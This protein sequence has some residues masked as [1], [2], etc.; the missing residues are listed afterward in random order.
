MYSQNELNAIVKKLQQDGW[1]FV[2]D[3]AFPVTDPRRMGWWINDEHETKCRR[4]GD[5]KP[6][7]YATEIVF[8]AYTNYSLRDLNVKPAWLTPEMEATIAK[9]KAI[10]EKQARQAKR[11]AKR[12]AATA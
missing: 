7:Y 9:N 2:E 6:F 1:Y 8:T 4:V 11:E 12:M 5:S 10:A 3:Q